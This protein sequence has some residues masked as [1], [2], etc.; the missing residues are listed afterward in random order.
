VLA[1]AI[2]VTYTQAWGSSVAELSSIAYDLAG[3]DPQRIVVKVGSEGSLHA[4]N[5]AMWLVTTSY[6]AY[7]VPCVHTAFA[8]VYPPCSSQQHWRVFRWVDAG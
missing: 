6:T 1:K 5:S 4:I 8:P 2:S 7:C 3:I